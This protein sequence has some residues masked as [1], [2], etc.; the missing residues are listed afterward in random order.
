MLCAWAAHGKFGQML[1]Y[2][3]IGVQSQLEVAAITMVEFLLAWANKR[4]R[5]ES[6]TGLTAVP[7]GSTSLA[8]RPLTSVEGTRIHGFDNTQA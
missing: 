4:C 3:L 6:S 5:C 7:F 1:Y 2:R 8:S